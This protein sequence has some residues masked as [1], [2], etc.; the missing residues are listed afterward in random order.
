MVSVEHGE[1]RKF[2]AR[3]IAFEDFAGN[4]LPFV[5]LVIPGEIDDLVSLAVFRPQA[6]AFPGSVVGNHLVGRF[7]NAHGGTVILLQ[8]DHPGIFVLLF[9]FQDVFDGGPPE[10]IDAL[11]IVAHH[12]DISISPGQQAAQHILGV[13]CV[14]VLVHQHIAE[15]A[16]VMLPHIAALL[17]QM[18]GLHDDVVKIHGPGPAHPVLVF[19]VN[20][21]HGLL[22]IVVSGLLLILPGGD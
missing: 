5:L 15:L 4:K 20:T 16:L 19:F 1:I 2:L 3:P 12:A 7:Q 11:V 13:V 21:A 6:L 18:D 14:L 17:E 22:V 10:F 9:K 8:A